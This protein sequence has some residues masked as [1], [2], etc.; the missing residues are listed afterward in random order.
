MVGSWCYWPIHEN[1]WN[2]P[3]NLETASTK[4]NCIRR[5]LL[6]T[7]AGWRGQ[8][9]VGKH[10]WA[11]KQHM[12]GPVE[13]TRARMLCEARLQYEEGREQVAR[14]LPHGGLCVFVGK[15]P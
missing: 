10:S 8:T 7:L 5:G 4:P 9:A 13:A 6:R 3:V 14:A 11:T 12:C 2:L 1:P 15:Q